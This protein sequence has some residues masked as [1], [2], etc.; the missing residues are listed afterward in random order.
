MGKALLE[1]APQDIIDQ[2]VENLPPVD[3][4]NAHQ[5]GITTQ[6]YNQLKHACMWAKLFKKSDWLEGAVCAGAHPALVGHGVRDLYQN[7]GKP[8]YAFLL[9]L[10]YVG[11]SRYVRPKAIK[12]LRNYN[13][14]PL[15]HN[16]YIR[17]TNLTVHICNVANTCNG[18]ACRDHTMFE[19]I[20]Q[21]VAEETIA[22]SSYEMPEKPETIR[23][24]LQLLPSIRY[25][26]RCAFAIPNAKGELIEWVFVPEANYPYDRIVHEDTIQS[27]IRLQLNTQEKE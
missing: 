11:D 20:H 25:R 2:I 26:I 4:W 6:N 8:V 5:A 13:F 12:C 19:S 27:G 10:D 1:T 16:V 23:I 22:I 18:L 15:R 24:K 21:L 14:D 3:R 17:S 7:S 9:A